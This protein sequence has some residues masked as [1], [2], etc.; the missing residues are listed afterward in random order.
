LATESIRALQTDH[1]R[2]VQSI[3]DSIRQ[4]RSKSER[5]PSLVS[6]VR[7]ASV[8]GVFSPAFASPPPGH[9]GTSDGLGQQ[10]I[11]VVPQGALFSEPSPSRATDALISQMEYERRRIQRL[12]EQV[13]ERDR[14]LAELKVAEAERERREVAMRIRMLETM[15]AFRARQQLV[16]REVGGLE[17][18]KE[19]GGVI[20]R[21]LPPH[22]LLDEMADPDD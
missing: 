4:E 3:A 17:R 5:S 1:L 14:M 12:E 11:M 20:A 19:M 8:G 16:E 10:Q 18:R 6:G 7:A 2:E 22:P 9:P 15:A 21:H 13:E